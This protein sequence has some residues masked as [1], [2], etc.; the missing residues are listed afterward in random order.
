MLISAAEQVKL[1][2]KILGHYRLVCWS[3]VVK[4][5]PNVGS[6]FF[7]KFPSNRIPRT[8]NRVNVRYAH[9][10]NKRSN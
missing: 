5:K 1:S 4:E 8:T 9:N 3:I 2:Y 6:P 10:F 7:W